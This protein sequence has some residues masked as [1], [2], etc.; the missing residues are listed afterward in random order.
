MATRDEMFPSKYL[1]A[2]DVP[3][4]RTATVERASVEMVGQGAKAEHKTVL[5][6][7]NGTFK[8]LVVNATNWDSMV[9]ISGFDN[10][11]HWGG[12]VVELFAVDVMGPSGMARGVRIRRPQPRKKGKAAPAAPV[13]GPDDPLPDE[14]PF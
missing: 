11:D 3:Q 2:S 7:V 5:Y 10:S 1:K 9:L 6:F 4:P 13:V 8:P 14:V 12:T